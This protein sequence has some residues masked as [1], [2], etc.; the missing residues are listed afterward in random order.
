V[1]KDFTGLLNQ[2]PE[3]LKEMGKYIKLEG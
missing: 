2:P 3:V 1:L